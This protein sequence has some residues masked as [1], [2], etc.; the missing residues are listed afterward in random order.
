MRKAP[1]RQNLDADFSFEN[2][3]TIW[4]CR[5]NNEDA[6]EHLSTHVQEDAQWFGNAV[7]VEHRYVSDLAQHL[8]DDG[9]SVDGE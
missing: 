7:A 6:R 1:E 2:H 3:G 4:L 9:F 5:P 8:Q